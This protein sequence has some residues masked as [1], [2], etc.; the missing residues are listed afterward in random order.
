MSNE[1][2]A[3]F[4]QS[5]KPFRE[6][7]PQYLSF[8]SESKFAKQL[9]LN[10]SFLHNVAV[11]CPRSLADAIV[12]VAS[13]GL[14]LNPAEKLAYLIPRNIK[15]SKDKYQTRIFLDVSY[16]GLIRLATDSGSIKWI[17]AN[18]VYSS[19]TFA[20]NGPGEK[21]THSYSPFAKK[22]DRGDFVGVY[23][24]AKTKDGDYLTEIMPAEDVYSIRDRSESFKKYGNGPWKD[25]FGEM[26]KKAV[27]RR[28]FK[29][30]PRTNERMMERL[31]QAVELSNQN[32]G[33]APILTTPEMGQ[34]TAE[35]KEYF[36]QMITQSEAWNMFVFRKTIEESTYTNLY[37][38]FEKGTKG[39]YQKAIDSLL[40]EGQE[41]FNRYIA[42]IEAATQSGDSFAVYEVIEDMPETEV[43][44]L[45]S[46]LSDDA[47]SM[48]AESK[49]AA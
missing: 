22:D 24:V 16:M 37:H 30:L 2:A 34:Y 39:K 25:D 42:D 19:D 13:I 48:V 17:R 44:L 1:L 20:D 3:V 47:I 8:E 33:F 14:S 31:A 27:I 4:E 41:L 23:A 36:D 7:A 9:L 6:I 46:A 43:E 49:N 45:K 21:P 15:V 26:A 32:E 5:E 18:L 12:N 10:N 11:S 28:M 35:Q 40:A 29:T 38:S